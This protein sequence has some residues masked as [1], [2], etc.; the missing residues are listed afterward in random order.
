MYF[1]AR[2]FPSEYIL[3]CHLSSIVQAHKYTVVGTVFSPIST[4]EMPAI[5]PSVL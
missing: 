3:L 2:A 1:S 5:S 4:V